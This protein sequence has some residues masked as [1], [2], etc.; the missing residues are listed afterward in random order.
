MDSCGNGEKQPSFLVLSHDYQIDAVEIYD[1]LSAFCLSA[2]SSN[3]RHW[4]WVLHLL[5]ICRLSCA[6]PRVCETLPKVPCIRPP[7]VVKTNRIHED[8]AIAAIGLSKRH[9]Y[10]LERPDVT[11]LIPKPGEP[12]PRFSLAKVWWLKS[13]ADT[14]IW[15]KGTSGWFLHL[16]PQWPE[17]NGN[18][19][20]VC[21]GLR[22]QRC[23]SRT[24]EVACALLYVQHMEENMLLYVEVNTCRGLYA[25][26]VWA[27]ISFYSN[28]LNSFVL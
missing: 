22:V 23:N 10:Q 19:A 20:A 8:F 28:S 11:R 5:Q 2:W 21:I 18:M 15:M 6:L 9:R 1:P 26:K 7:I 27:I 16:I 4:P 13:G 14:E 3:V 17:R 12:P 24:G 25:G